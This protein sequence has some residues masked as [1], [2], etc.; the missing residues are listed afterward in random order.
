M[1]VKTHAGSTR[2]V[3]HAAFSYS[4]EAF[5]RLIS[6][7]QS[8]LIAMNSSRYI[9]GIDLGTTHTAMAYADL[10]GPAQPA[11]QTFAIAQTVRPGAAET[12]VL[13]PSCIYLPAEN[14]FPAGSLTLPWS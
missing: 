3:F 8:G 13:L 9:V 12:S 6:H 11:I 14:E 1:I 7:G 2:I 4:S 10:N 5:F